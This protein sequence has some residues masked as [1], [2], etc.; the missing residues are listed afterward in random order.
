MSRL[1]NVLEVMTGGNFNNVQIL[2]LREFA[3]RGKPYKATWMTGKFIDTMKQKYS[4]GR[5]RQ[6]S[7]LSTSEVEQVERYYADVALIEKLVG[8]YKAN[9]FWDYVSELNRSPSLMKK[10]GFKSRIV[11][12]L[13]TYGFHEGPLCDCLCYLNSWLSKNR[14]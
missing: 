13:A 8:L 11:H 7:G 5:S 9:K 14:P 4:S 1:L 3:V 12:S 10:I 6:L 2:I